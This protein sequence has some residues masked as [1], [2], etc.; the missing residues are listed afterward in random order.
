MA[1]MQWHVKARVICMETHVS[2]GPV[3]SPASGGVGWGEGAE[4]GGGEEEAGSY[5][6]RGDL[7]DDAV[8]LARRHP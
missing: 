5:R 8:P 3:R 4:K 2:I 7:C 1:C 6:G